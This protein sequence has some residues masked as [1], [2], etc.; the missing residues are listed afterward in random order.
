LKHSLLSSSRRRPSPTTTTTTTTTKSNDRSDDCCLS[1]CTCQLIMAAPSASSSP[2]FGGSRGP[3]QDWPG[4]R[5]ISPRFPRRVLRWR[6]AM[7]G[8]WGGR[9]K[10]AE[11]G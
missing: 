1:Q 6:A 3:L 11:R 9:E 5:P 7:D 4:A 2:K 8:E 10:E